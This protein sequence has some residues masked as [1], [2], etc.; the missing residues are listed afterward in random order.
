MALILSSY[1]MGYFLGIKVAYAFPGMYFRL[2]TSNIVP[3][4]TDTIDTYNPYEAT[5]DGYAAQPMPTSWSS[6]VISNPPP[7]ATISAL[8]SVVFL[9]TG[10]TTPNQV[11]GY[12]V[13][14]GDATPG[15]GTV[16]YFAEL[17]PTGP[18]TVGGDYVPYVIAPVFGEQ[19]IT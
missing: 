9:P 16:L 1:G 15:S 11:Y 2:F 18:V 8:S 6:A 4:Y 7:A 17:N 10:T 5:F 13:T 12:Y 3:A 19:S 14:D